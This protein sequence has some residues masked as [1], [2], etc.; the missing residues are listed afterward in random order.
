MPP[1]PAEP[2]VLRKYCVTERSSVEIVLNGEFEFE[3]LSFE[4]RTTL[5]N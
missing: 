1:E 5:R 3:T 2:A 4:P